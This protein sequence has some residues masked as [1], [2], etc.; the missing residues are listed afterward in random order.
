MVNGYAGG[1]PVLVDA[2][3]T[4]AGLGAVGELTANGTVEPG[5][6]APFTGQLSS[7][8][9]TFSSTANFT[10]EVTGV[11]DGPYS[12]LLYAIG[13]VGTNFLANATLTVVPV[14]TAPLALGQQI[15]ILNGLSEAAPCCSVYNKISGTFNGLP[16]GSGFSVDG[17]GFQISYSTNQVVLTVTNLPPKPVITGIQPAAGGGFQINGI[18]STNLTYTVWASTNLTTTN[19]MTI[20][21]V[22]VPANTNVFQFTDTNT[23]YYVDRFYRFTWP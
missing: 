4:L 13:P 2:G 11:S 5:N 20:G 22:M 23:M 9:V 18:G 10:V 14:F 16:N 8:D 15:I 1:I 12:D 7:G 6:P 3:A 17:F 19:W 21:S